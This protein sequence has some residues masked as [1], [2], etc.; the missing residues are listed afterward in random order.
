M[1]ALLFPGQGSQFVGM[2][3]ELYR[4][5][6]LVK[7]LFKE[8]DHKLH[9][10]ISK[11]ILEGPENELKLTKNTQPAILTISH[12]IFKVI[13]EEFKIKIKNIKYFAGHSL[14]E[15]SALVSSGSLKFSDALY[16]VHERGKAMQESVPEGQGAMLAV[17]GVAPNKVEEYIKKIDK[18]N[19]E[20]EIANDNSDSQIILSGNRKAI[21]EMHKLM[22]ENKKK[23]MFLPVIAPFHSSLMKTAA[24]NMKDK[25]QNTSFQNPSID[26]VT[27]V[28]AQ[29]TKNPE[30]IKKL[31]VDQ[32]YSKVRWRES[33]LYMIE[34]GVNEFIE[35]GPGKVLT[36]LVKR[37]SGKVNVKSINTISD[38]ETL[39]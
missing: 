30:E 35:I 38:I 14:G 13:T 3:S 31:L 39:K 37:I 24:Q 21:E 20:C 28:T 6:S 9:Y 16:L 10:S 32:I 2:G 18:K 12:S 33:I 27:N 29:S 8:A 1:K 5:F 25:I 26:L 19:G 36:G 7:N 11:L 34:N 22:K 4:E 23:S 17:L 15:Y